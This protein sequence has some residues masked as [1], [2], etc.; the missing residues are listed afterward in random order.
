MKKT[1]EFLKQMMK[2]LKWLII[3]VILGLI[4]WGIAYLISAVGEILK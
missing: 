1:K 3:I 2:K 4:I